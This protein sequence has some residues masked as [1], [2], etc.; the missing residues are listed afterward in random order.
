MVICT[1]YQ[2]LNFPHFLVYAYLSICNFPYFLTDKQKTK[3]VRHLNFR[4]KNQEPVDL[5]IF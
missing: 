1:N 3:K 2:N 5:E 4:A